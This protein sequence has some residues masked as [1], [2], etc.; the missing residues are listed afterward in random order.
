MKYIILFAVLYFALTN[1][2]GFSKIVNKG[3][4]LISGTVNSTISE[5]K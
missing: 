4:H 2:D 3:V 5:V 1:P